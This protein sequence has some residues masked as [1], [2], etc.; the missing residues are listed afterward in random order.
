ML[1]IANVL[2]DA[3]LCP[4]LVDLPAHGKSAGARSSVAQFSRALF[5]LQDH[6]GPFHGV[7][8]HSAGA[9]AS[10]YAIAQSLVAKRLVLIAPPT[11][12]LRMV[13]SIAI[14]FSLPDSWTHRLYTRMGQD[15][16]ICVSKFDLDNTA[17]NLLLPTLIVHDKD[18]RV[19]PVSS[20]RRITAWLPQGQLLI[21]E[22][23]GHR[24]LLQDADVASRILRHMTEALPR[25]AAFTAAPSIKGCDATEIH[26]AP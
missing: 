21:T 17:H 4:T 25:D 22:G 9:L 26:H 5:A 18:D 20:S 8:A 15:E 24:R 12:T 2:A 6:L 1:T 3:G 14:A 16:G 13:Q 11:S 7:V 23:L 10:A 19:V